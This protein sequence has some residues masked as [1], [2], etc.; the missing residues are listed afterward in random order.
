MKD[1]T[2]ALHGRKHTVTYLPIYRLGHI[3]LVAHCKKLTISTTSKLT[4]S[5]LLICRADYR[6]S[7]PEVAVLL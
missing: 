5:V 6:L 4:L 3:P 2:C 1:V 7:L